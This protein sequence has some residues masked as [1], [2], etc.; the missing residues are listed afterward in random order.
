MYYYLQVGE[1]LPDVFLI[2]ALQQPVEIH[3]YPRRYAADEGHTFIKCLF[4][5][6]VQF[7]FPVLNAV[8]FIRWQLV[9]A[10]VTWYIVINNTTEP[11]GRDTTYTFQ[12]RRA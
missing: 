5:Y 7:G 10:Q 11:A 6:L 2:S 9:T 8:C 12:L 3:L 4:Y 1:K